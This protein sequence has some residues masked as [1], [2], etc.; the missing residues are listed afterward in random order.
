M[1]TNLSDKGSKRIRWSV[2][3]YSAHASLAAL[4]PVLAEKAIF[5]PIHQHVEIL[6]KEVRY[7]PT[8]KLIFVT[9]G[10]LS[11]SRTVYDINHTLRVDH[12]LVNAFGYQAC[13]DQS[14]IQETLNA[15]TE[16]NV[17]QL[18]GALEQIWTQHNLTAPLLEKAFETSEVVTVDMDLSGQP[19]SKKAQQATKG[20]FPG[21]KN[22]YGRQLARVLV[23]DTQEIVTE[24]LYPGNTTPCMVF[25][26][27]VAKME[28]RL[29]LETKAQRRSV[30]L[31]LDG[32]FGTDENLNYALW[33]GYHLLAKMYSGKRAK[34]LAQAVQQW[35]DVPT[36]TK[37]AP[38]QAGWIL[39]PHRYGRKTRQGAVRMPKK[40]G[41]YSYSVLVVTEMEADLHT[42]LK[43][44]DQRGGVPES[45]F[46]QDY[47]GLG[48]RKRRKRD[49][50]PQQMVTLLSQLAHNLIRWIQHWMIQAVEQTP[51][52]QPISSPKNN[53]LDRASIV[54]I[55]QQRGM[56]RFVNHILS[57]SGKVILKRGKVTRVIL[58]PL[59]PLSNRIQTA[60]AALLNNYQTRVSLGKT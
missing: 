23:P 55:L 48:L 43:D 57:L 11:G 6:Q 19:C 52:L 47:Q 53:S 33:R 42:L 21:K 22:T 59:Y 29:G 8:D 17:L 31:R 18:E 49:F 41:G 27:M 51:S 14:V 26:D 38:R 54:K 39:T 4:A 28:H 56:K 24:H 7:R 60:F 34:A 32:G 13:A 5:G 9:L 10:I 20:Y 1:A 25:K 30:R 36:Q 44:Y 3:A 35:V 12:P 2:K 40:K 50:V 46:C 58:N 45:T 15:S 16:A 37:E